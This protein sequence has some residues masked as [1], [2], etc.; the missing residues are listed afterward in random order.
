MIPTPPPGF[1]QLME[2]AWA[3]RTSKAFLVACDLGV[4][5]HLSFPATAED[6]AA[7]LQVNPR[8]LGLLLHGLAAL[9]LVIKEGE[10]FRNAPVA[11]EY[12]V[13]GRDNYRGAI[14]KHL[15]HTWP[16][17]SD[18]GPV[19]VTG[20]PRD[21]DPGGWVDSHDEAREE[22]I[23]DFI[24][25]MHA[26][27]RD[28]LPAVLEQLDL[29]GAT[30]L[31]DLG[32]GPATYAI[33]FVQSRPGLQ[34][35]VFDLP[36][37]ITIAQQNIRSQGLV[38][39]ISIVTGNFLTDDLGR[40]YDFIWISQILHAL[41][42][43]QCRLLLRKAAA[44][45]TPG[46]RLAVHEFFLNDDGYTPPTAA[47]FGLHMLAVTP[48]GRAYKHAEVATW[49]EEVGVPAPEF[50]RVNDHSAIL[51]GAKSA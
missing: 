45:L 34:A 37:P 25:G 26:I 15:H 10:A 51:I 7:R 14:F 17:W 30:R 24:G 1:G 48:G 40:D 21:T 42:E 27:A 16:A 29:S 32:G 38:D 44:A 12:L 5:N 4:F 41:D 2:L 47:F 18:L 9:G 50:R 13:S 39:R 6:L 36:L 3:F 49:M 28:T 8:A 33:G 31:L 43:S 11:E 20:G 46:G 22:E 19:V 23:R 35:T